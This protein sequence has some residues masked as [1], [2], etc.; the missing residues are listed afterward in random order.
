M[1]TCRSPRP[2]TGFASRKKTGKK[3]KG[4][5][6]ERSKGYVELALP[7]QKEEQPQPGDTAS[8]GG[9]GGGGGEGG[10]GGGGKGVLEEDRGEGSPGKYAM[11]AQLKQEIREEG[12]GKRAR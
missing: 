11:L 7:Q 10:G 9:G 12:L 2:K 3:P 4:S 8:G 5:G 1:C 6:I